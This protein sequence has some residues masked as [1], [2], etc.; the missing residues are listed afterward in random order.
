MAENSYKK[1]L[2]CHS[3]DHLKITPCGGDR[4]DF[5]LCNKCGQSWGGEDMERC[6]HCLDVI[7]YC[8]CYRDY[9]DKK[10]EK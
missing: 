6:E 8:S 10:N 7:M 9:I 5:Y 4:S 2:Y 1:C 3:P